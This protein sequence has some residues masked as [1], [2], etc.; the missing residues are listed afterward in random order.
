MDSYP[1][2]FPGTL[3]VQAPGSTL[4]TEFAHYCASLYPLGH[5]FAGVEWE[6]SAPISIPTGAACMS[7]RRAGSW[8][9]HVLPAP[10]PIPPRGTLLTSL[11]WVPGLWRH[12]GTLQHVLLAFLLLWTPCSA[13]L[14]IGAALVRAEGLSWQQ[15]ILSQ[16]S[17]LQPLPWTP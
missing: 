3:L 15:G 4:P 13:A 10:N 6:S 5:G 11:S 12:V 2:G 1:K 17:Q 8:Q 7:D 16:L 9:K 14:G